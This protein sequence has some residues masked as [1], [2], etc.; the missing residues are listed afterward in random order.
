[1]KRKKG[2]SPTLYSSQRRVI[3]FKNIFLQSL[4]LF[5]SQQICSP[6]I[7]SMTYRQEKNCGF[8]S[9]IS[10]QA[11]LD[12]CPYHCDW[13]LCFLLLLLDFLYDYGKIHCC[14][15]E[16]LYSYSP[17][18]WGIWQIGSYQ[19][20]SETS[21]VQVHFPCSISQMLCSILQSYCSS[22][23]SFAL[24][25]KEQNTNNAVNLSSRT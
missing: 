10:I 22:S 18:Y 17:V 5:Y 6:S 15:N 12:H 11:Q 25:K 1:M 21:S 16:L 14:P 19:I 20:E 2:P 13:L 9:R 7:S 4:L 24:A 8:S 3:W 23:T